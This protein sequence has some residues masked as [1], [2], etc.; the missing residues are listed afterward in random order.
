MSTGTATQTHARR[1]AAPRRPCDRRANRGAV[2]EKWERKVEVV[3]LLPTAIRSSHASPSRRQARS[4]S[5][6]PRKTASAFGLPNRRLAPPT[7][8]RRSARKGR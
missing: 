1:R 8:G 7:R 4:A 6:S 5:V 2:V 3:R